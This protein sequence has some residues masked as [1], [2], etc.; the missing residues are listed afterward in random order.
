[1]R[2]IIGDLWTPSL[3]ASGV[4]IDNHTH[5]NIRAALTY[6]KGPTGENLLVIT[7]TPDGA[8]AIA[9]GPNGVETQ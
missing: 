2:S 9:P 7:L 8:I 5:Q 4:R 6:E 1:M 3:K